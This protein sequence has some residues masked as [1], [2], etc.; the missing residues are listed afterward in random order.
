M[1]TSRMNKLGDLVSIVVL[2]MLGSAGCALTPDTE[3]PEE[4]D[5]S[6]IEQGVICNHFYDGADPYTTGCANDGYWVNSAPS[7]QV[8]I[9]NTLIS[10][11]LWYSPSCGTN[12]TRLHSPTEVPYMA[13][14]VVRQQDPNY[15]Q[16][17]YKYYYRDGTWLYTDMVYAPTALAKACGSI[18]STSGPWTC[19]GWY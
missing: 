19:T 8:Y 2:M 13:G 7:Q 14:R 16:A 11:Q 5:L 10:V 1:R 18:V 17:I 6:T 12:W 15:C 3:Q 4:E 9:P